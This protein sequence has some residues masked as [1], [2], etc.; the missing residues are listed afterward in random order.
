MSIVTNLWTN[1]SM[2]QYGGSNGVASSTNQ[3]WLEHP[4]TPGDYVICADLNGCKQLTVKSGDKGNLPYSIWPHAG[5]SRMSLAFTLPEDKTGLIVQA[6]KFSDSTTVSV[7]R[8]LLV[9]KN[10]WTVAQQVLGNDLPYFD[11]ATMPLAGV[12]GGGIVVV[13]LN[14]SAMVSGGW[15]HDP[16]YK[17]VGE[18][19]LVSAWRC[20]RSRHVE[21][22]RVVEY[23]LDSGRLRVRDQLARI[24]SAPDLR[25]K[26]EHAACQREQS[27]IESETSNQ[28]H[29]TRRPYHGCNPVDGQQWYDRTGIPATAGP[30]NRVGVVENTPR[31]R[32]A[33]F[34]RRSHATHLTHTATLNLG[35]AA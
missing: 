25:G 23:S 19:V 6:L 1:P 12:G 29:V 26:P 30:A 14:P 9:T 11:G 13:I 28:V 17:L 35:V 18:S 31:R 16:H 24:I 15:R 7:G 5:S 10:D 20:Q 33:V 27:V 22:E 4:L 3:M 8:I 2:S 21:S 32:P 34:R